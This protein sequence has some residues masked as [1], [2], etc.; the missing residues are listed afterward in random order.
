MVVGTQQA[1]SAYLS[2]TLGNLWRGCKPMTMA[3]TLANLRVLHRI[4][5][6][7]LYYSIMFAPHGEETLN[8]V[9]WF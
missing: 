2:M 7:S 6:I 9:F 4:S 5:L 8:N 1:L 3:M